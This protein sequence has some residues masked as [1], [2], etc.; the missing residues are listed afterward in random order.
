VT[1]ETNQRIHLA[2]LCH[3]WSHDPALNGKQADCAVP[4]L[5]AKITGWNLRDKKVRSVALPC[6][7]C[8]KSTDI[9][10]WYSHFDAH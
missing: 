2:Q 8:T 9:P 1:A 10:P 5:D 3:D 4:F 6:W 7:L